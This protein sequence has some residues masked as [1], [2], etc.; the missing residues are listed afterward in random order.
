MQVWWGVGNYQGRQNYAA[1]TGFI[2]P[3]L[4]VAVVGKVIQITALCARLRFFLTRLV[5]R[6]QC[7]HTR[8]E[9]V[10]YDSQILP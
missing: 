10:S 9:I 6:S 5:T 2:M 7:E 4:S 1:R 3:A 8:G